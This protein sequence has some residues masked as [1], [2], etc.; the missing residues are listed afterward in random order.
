MLRPPPTTVWDLLCCQGHFE[1]ILGLKPKRRPAPTSTSPEHEGFSCPGLWGPG[2]CAEVRQGVIPRGATEPSQAP[3]RTGFWN[4][5]THA[6]VGGDPV[7]ALAAPGRVWHLQFQRQ[8]KPCWPLS[9]GETEARSK[10]THLLVSALPCAQFCL[11][12]R[13]GPG[14]GWKAPAA[15]ELEGAYLPTRREARCPVCSQV[16]L[17]NLS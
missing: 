14:K 12:P 16:H 9:E 10:L 8:I 3:Q 13:E 7:R 4:L 17:M 11:E 1:P 6:G 2:A 5:L 15:S